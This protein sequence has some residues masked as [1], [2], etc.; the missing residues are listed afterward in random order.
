MSCIIDVPKQVDSLDLAVA[1]WSPLC[2]VDDHLLDGGGLLCG[3]SA[4]ADE[5][6]AVV[7]LH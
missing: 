3:S 2:T 6:A 4:A 7:G 1:K 5:G